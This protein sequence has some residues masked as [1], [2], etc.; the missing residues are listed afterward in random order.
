MTDIHTAAIRDI[1]PAA[2]APDGSRPYAASNA[3]RLLCIGARTDRAFQER[4]IEELHKNQ[5]RVVAPAYGY[6]TVPVLAHAVDARNLRTKRIACTVLAG[7]TAI[8]LWFTG[9]T[10]PLFAFC[11]F[12]WAAWLGC[13]LELVVNTQILI[14]RLKRPVQGRRGFDGS[15]PASVDSG[16]VKQIT[17]EQDTTADLVYY[18]SYIPFIGAGIRSSAHWSFAVLLEPPLGKLDALNPQPSSDGNE[19]PQIHSFTVEE[20][21]DHVETTLHR[22]LSG[23]AAAGHEVDQVV[24]ERRR[25]R[26]AVGTSR[27]QALRERDDTQADTYDSAREYLCVHVGSWAQELV[28]SLFVSFDVR[29]GMLYSELHHYVLP[30]ITSR[31]HEVDELPYR[32]DLPDLLAL[33]GRSIAEVGRA[34]LEAAAAI[35]KVFGWVVRHKQPLTAQAPDGERHGAMRDFGARVSI[36]QLAAVRGFHH[37][38]QASDAEKYT[39]I[40]ERRLLETVREFLE[41]HNVDTAEFRE[42]EASVLNIGIANTGGGS[43]VNSGA[44]SFGAGSKAQTGGSL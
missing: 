1:S 18:G 28:V 35:F 15:Y 20:L 5:Q 43:V 29:G 12:L 9:A 23:R 34:G 42:R 14:T 10:N 3:T 16:L 40:V 17:A 21:T 44:Q 38:F 30:P 25:Y 8:V 6:D 32:L 24:V 2:S 7:F 36:R 37:F 39:K 41:E 4:V 31:Y 19:G 13:F 27:G 11:L 33:A 26:K 22:R